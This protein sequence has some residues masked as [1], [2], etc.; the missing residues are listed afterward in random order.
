VPLLARAAGAAAAD[1]IPDGA[2]VVVV[3]DPL[4][5]P[6]ACACVRGYAQRNYA[7]LGTYLEGKVGRP[8]K[9]VFAE[10]MTAALGKTGG[11]ADLVIGKESAVVAA[12]K[13]SK[14]GVTRVA[15]LTGLDG[16]TTHTGLVVVASDDPAVMADNLKGYRILFGPADATETHDAALDLLKDLEVAVP[17]EPETCPACSVGATKMLALH[18]QGV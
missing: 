13:A 9:V 6:L 1:A 7:K 14:L 3:A 8:V 5:A 18:K 2:L 11:R 12:A 17:A 4:A 15:A 10:T 16:V